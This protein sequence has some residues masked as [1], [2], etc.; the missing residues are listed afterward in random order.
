MVEIAGTI[1]GVLTSASM[2][3]QFF[4]LI[5]KK[6]SK[7]I[8]IGMLLALIAGVGCWIWYGLLKE[9]L[10]III[11]SSFSVFLNMLI[12]VFAIKYRRR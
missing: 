5:Q 4:K 12:L 3:P 2:I 7:D 10:I 1:A 9:D 6:D 11:T 8:S